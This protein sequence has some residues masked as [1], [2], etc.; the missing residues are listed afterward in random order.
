MKKFICYVF[1]L[2]I[3]LASSIASLEAATLINSLPYTINSQGS[4]YINKNLSSTGNGILVKRNN[5][6]IDLRGYTIRGPGTGVN[7]GIYMQGAGAGLTNVEI[8]NG[9]VRNFGH[10]GIRESYASGKNH[11]VI[12]VRA[13]SNGVYGI[14]LN[15]SNHLIEGCTVSHNGNVGIYNGGYGSTITGNTSYHN[16]G[17]GIHAGDG[18]TVT[19][20]TAYDNENGGITAFDGSTVSGNTAYSNGGDGIKTDSG[21]TVKNN[22]ANYNQYD[23]INP[24]SYNLVDGNTAYD[25]NKSLGGYSNISTCSMCVFGTNSAP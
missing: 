2:L 12:N 3:A 24:G 15:G 22:T 25:N 8:K 21:C 16:K 13:I 23:G 18:C 20:N 7:Y 5:V 4:Y 9:T 6:T 17:A 11:R 1:V 10:S 19:G 14:G